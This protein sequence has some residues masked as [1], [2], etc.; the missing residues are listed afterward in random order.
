MSPFILRIVWLIGSAVIYVIL[1]YAVPREQFGLLIG[2][3]TGLFFGYVWILKRSVFPS[4]N[5]K[6]NKTARWLGEQDTYRFLFA[7]A[8]LFRLLL[9]FAM[10]QL[11]DDVYRFIW[12]GRLL[13]HGYNP[14]MHL[15]RQL[16]DTPI[17]AACG[18]DQWLFGQL[19]SPDYF[20]VYPPFNQ[21]L[22]WLAS[23]L[24]PTN[25]TGNAVWLRVP[26]V[27]SELGSIWLL[28][29]LLRRFSLSPNLAFLYSLN[30][31]VILELTGNL[32]FE[33]V[34]IFFTLLATWLL[35]DGRFALSAGALALAIGTKL[36]PL[37]L[38]PLVIRRIGWKPGIIYTLLTGLLTA[39]LFAPFA[40]L[41]L[42]QNIFSSINLYFQKFEF[43]ASLYYILRAVGYWIKGYNTIKFIGVVLSGTI[44]LSTLWIAFR[45]RL[46]PASVQ[47]LA[48]LTVY[49]SFATTVHPWY[50]TTLL[51]ASV[52]T[53]FRYPLVWSALIPLSYFTY[54]TAP[55]E[56]NLW[57]TALEYSIVL[58]VGTLEII[59][60]RQRLRKG[61]NS[62]S[63]TWQWSA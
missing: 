35:L 29:T 51:A 28:A 6:E 49:L 7:S 63:D 12:D 15:P 38:L 27:V 14:Y 34:M 2:L 9:L 10:P 39:A 61:I 52:F 21:A 57:L 16:L 46:I 32:H 1:A 40:S 11:S 41:E 42:A 3:L 30:P 58:V 4:F 44:L 31:V 59:N 45:W 23:W 33:A 55:Y 13:V 22:F 37:L 20:T 17:A 43:N 36:L 26:I 62:D 24:S 60:Y 18:L 54:H 48:I 56:E 47:L 8:I 53:P 19:N 25:L 5:G 50:V